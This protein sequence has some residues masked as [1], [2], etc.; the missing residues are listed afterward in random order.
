MRPLQGANWRMIEPPPIEL[1]MFQA[2]IDAAPEVVFWTDFD[3]RLVYVNEQARA[4]LGYDREELL[5]LHVWDVDAELTREAWSG[6]WAERSAS[7]MR[8]TWYR[9]RDGSLVPVEV[10]SRNLETS[11]A[12]LRVSFARDITERRAVT[13]ALRRTQAAVDRAREA[14]FWIRSDARLVYVN[15]AA[16]ESLGY[17]REELL[18]MKVMDFDPNVSEAVWEKD[19]ARSRE[20]RSF[21]AETAHRAKSGRT[22]PVEVAISFM[23]FKGE[24]YNCVYTRDISERK[25]A[26]EEKARLQSQL[27]HAQKLESV[28]RL[29]G[30]V[31]HDFNNMLSVILGYTELITKRLPPGDPLVADLQEIKKAACRS[32]DTTRQLLAFSRRQIITPRPVDLNELVANAQNT[33]LRLIG[34]DVELRFVAGRDLWQVVFDP[35]QLEQVLVNLIVNARDALSSTG[36]ITIETSNLRVDEAFCRGHPEATPGEYVAL[37]VTDD[38]VGIDADTLGHIF[39]PFFTTKGVGRG[40]GLGLATV[41]GAIKQNDGFIGVT[42]AP[43]R[44]SS[45]KLYIPRAR[46]RTSEA[47]VVAEPPA[48]RGQGTVLVVE[49]DDMVRHLTSSMLQELGYTVLTAATPRTAL[50]ICEKPDQRIDVLLSDVVMP[51]MQGSELRDRARALRPNL[52][53]LF[54][55][56]YTSDVVVH[57]G[58][59]DEGVEFLQKPFT[60]SDLA[61]SLRAT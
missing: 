23:Q 26:E 48:T 8:E 38:G 43:G 6:T 16:C 57:H 51:G 28:G 60:M 22:F 49:D 5:S 19:W 47:R 55:S 24:E 21:V 59:V 33:L 53:V 7:T 56:G 40:T 12:R 20:L 17:T 35:S 25:R 37:S 46:S 50:S 11:R 9:R 3:G 41:Y 29:A 32:R 34:E 4:S 2:A 31:A 44:G 58:V 61:R 18:R 45:F 39:E 27:L 10:S 13:D 42:S 30:G 15:D 14:I 36:T 1:A 52:P 54:M